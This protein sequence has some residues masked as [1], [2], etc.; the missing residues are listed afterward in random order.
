MR[1]AL[2]RAA[3]ALDAAGLNRNHAGNLSVRHGDGLLITPSGIP[4]GEL[5]AR[6]MVMLDGD[7][8]AAPDQLTVATRPGDAPPI[9]LGIGE[10]VIEVP[11][12][13]TEVVELS[14]P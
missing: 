5:T 8:S 11:A 14:S 12:G 3:R 1:E 2:V 10:T 4:A 6:S 9:R 13:S 7:G